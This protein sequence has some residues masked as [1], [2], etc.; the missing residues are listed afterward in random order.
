MSLSAQKHHMLEMCV[1]NVSIYSKESFENHF[2]DIQK[3]LRKWDPQGTWEYFFVIK[4]VFNPSHEKID[5]FTGAYFKR[6][7][8]IVSISP[9]VLILWSSA[10]CWASLW[11]TELH[12]YSVKHIDFVIKLD[13]VYSK[14]FV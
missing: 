10:H 11:S 9:E 5:I 4:L 7:F 8:D 14:P 3:V 2:N 1:I 12:Q 6:S 13:G